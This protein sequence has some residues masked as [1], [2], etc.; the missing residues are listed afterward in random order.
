MCY[1]NHANHIQKYNMNFRRISNEKMKVENSDI[2]ITENFTFIQ[3]YHNITT[4]LLPLKQHKTPK[5]NPFYL[6]LSYCLAYNPCK[7]HKL[8]TEHESLDT[9]IKTKALNERERD[10]HT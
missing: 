9:Y 1:T 8:Q 4:I 7:T 6:M 2:Y 5:P 3:I 10:T